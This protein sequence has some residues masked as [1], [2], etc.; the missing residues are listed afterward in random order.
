MLYNFLPNFIKKIFSSPPSPA[1]LTGAQ[2]KNRPAISAD[3][4]LSS[5]Q[6]DTLPNNTE[7]DVPTRVTGLTQEEKTDI[8]VA[9]DKY[10]EKH[11]RSKT[12]LPIP[13]ISEPPTQKVIQKDTQQRIDAG[14]AEVQKMIHERDKKNR[15]PQPELAPTENMIHPRV[16]AKATMQARPKSRPPQDDVPLDIS[17]EPTLPPTL[18]GQRL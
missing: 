10:N 11:P 7:T 6:L 4:A 18:P 16:E 15:P 5:Q 17:K 2:I 3:G 9:Q 14:I 1:P 13:N 12:E 8:L